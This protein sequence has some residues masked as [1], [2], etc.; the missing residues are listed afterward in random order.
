MTETNYWNTIATKYLTVWER[1][2]HRKILHIKEKTFITSAIHS[3][4]KISKKK[5]STYID[6]GCGPG[7]IIEIIQH[8]DTH[9]K[10]IIGVDSSEEMILLCKE[11]FKNAP[12][13]HY[14]L[15]TIPSDISKENGSV[16]VITAIRVLKYVKER[17]R[18]FS[19]VSRALSK[20]GIFI[21]TITNAHSLAYFDALNVHHYKDTVS[22]VTK[23]LKK[24]TLEIITLRGFQKLP[25]F[26]YIGASWL[27]ILPIIFSIET[28][29]QRIFG[30]SFFARTLYIVAQKK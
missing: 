16:D 9:Y 27:N 19:S 13:I 24:E 15:D 20:N 1:Y 21:F 7:R 23:Q 26:I 3:H 6:L 12:N 25:E 28:Y 29:L 2:T 4:K 18:I 14:I 8:S 17:E 5:A 30:E 10:K 22:V 11:R